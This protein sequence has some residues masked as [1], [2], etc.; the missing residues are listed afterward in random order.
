M[1]EVSSI[2]LFLQS[3]NSVDMILY[4]LRTV[5]IRCIF[6]SRNEL[7]FIQ[8]LLASS[9]SLGHLIFTYDTSIRDPGEKLRI[10]RKI[11]QFRRAST[12]AQIVWK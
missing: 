3:P 1:E 9:P 2:E 4:Q 11:K 7:Q 5:E 6:G 12:A 8:F 10:S